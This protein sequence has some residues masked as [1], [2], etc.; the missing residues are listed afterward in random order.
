M[1]LS[2]FIEANLPALIGDWADYA[3]LLNRG[4]SPLS[5]RELQNS[6]RALLLQIAADMRRTQSKAEQQNKSQG[7]K[8]NSDGGFDA[9]SALHADDRLAQGFD[10]NELIAEYRALRA[11]VLRRWQASGPAGTGAFQEM[12]RFNEAVDQAVAESVR[13][14]ARR[15]ERIRDLFA[16]VLAHDLRSPLGV[17]LNSADMLLRD[18][19]LSAPSVKAT[20]HVQRGALRIKRMIDDLLVFTRTRLGDTLPVSFT[21]LDMG[22]I[23]SDAVDEVRA[24]YPQA[25]IGLSYTGDLAGNWDGGR[26][27][28]L[29]VNLISN[30]VRYGTGDISVEAAGHD[31]RMT[32]VVYNEG[33]PIPARALPTLFD[34][35][36]RVDP[37]AERTGIAAGMGLGLYICRCIANAH[38][39][40]ISVES[41]EDGTRFTVEMSRHPRPPVSRTHTP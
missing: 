26:I 17:I 35:L 9:A 15:T 1:N 13:Q 18:E 22:R 38:D 6:A 32:L 16:G 8:R 20:A 27:G 30:A 33:N 21:P 40:T 31:G 24:L 41:L 23:C 25:M 5:R 28:Q 19:K 3:S 14:H 29:L 11:S 2:D 39:G 36:T 37:S 10:I 4:G 34:P 7:A 12:I